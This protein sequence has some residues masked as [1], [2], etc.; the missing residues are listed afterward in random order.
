MTTMFVSFA[1]PFLFV[2]SGLF[3]LAVLAL[4]WKAYG[5]ELA[6]LRAQL[7]AT[8]DLR[9]FEV[10]LAVTQVRELAP[11]VRRGSV[12]VRS[13]SAPARRPAGR[14]AAA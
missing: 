7:A 13:A 10:R 2:G 1:L 4:T 12:R 5:R 3:A 14:R 9:E 11:M 8:P 6:G